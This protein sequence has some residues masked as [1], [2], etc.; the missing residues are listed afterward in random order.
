M[1]KAL[2]RTIVIGLGSATALVHL[3]LGVTSFGNPLMTT[4]LSVLFVL[5]GFG[6]FTLLAWIFWADFP[7]KL[8]DPAMPH[9]L[10]MIYAAITLVAYFII[11]EPGLLGYVTKTIEV[12]L[13]A[14]TYWHLRAS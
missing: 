4:T 8:E 9:F 1:S 3:W 6:Y 11:G 10:L 14:A 12:L 2:L 13:I 5:N 7:I